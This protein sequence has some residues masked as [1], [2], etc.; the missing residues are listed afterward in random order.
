MSQAGLG[1]DA[2]DAA[3]LDADVLVIGS[4][5]GGA[6]SA[7]RLAEA[8]QRVIVTEQGQRIGPE[9]MRAAK[10]RPYTRLNWAP[11]LGQR[12]YFSQR[13]FR[14]VGILGGV[15][16]GGGS[17]VWGAVML[18]PKPRFY[19]ADVWQRL[20]LDFEAELAPHLDTARRM[21]GVAT[22]PRMSAQDDFLRATA[23]R[24][25]AGETFGPVPQAIHFG[26]P[27]RT[28]ADPYFDGAGPARTGCVF[29]AGCLSGCPHGAKS[30]LD[31]N[32]LHLA[33]RHGAD[34]R[35]GLRAERITPLDSMS[36]EGG[37]GY[38]VDF[39]AMD[40]GPAQRI[41][42]RRLVLAAGVL[43]TV[44]LLLTARD[45]H[46]TLPDVSPR[47]GETVRTNSEALTFILNRDA[48]IDLTDGASISS[49]FH[50]DAHTHITQNRMD[51]AYRIMRWM[52]VPMIDDA[53]PLRRAIKTL[54]ALVLR[55][56]IVW[57]NA[58]ARRYTQRLTT[59]TV[60]QD[61]DSGVGLTLR[62]PWWAPWRRRLASTP[63]AHGK[64]A[65][66]YL[67]VANRATRIFA[68]VSGGIPMS[69]SAEAI[70]G[71]AMTAHILGGCPMGS[72]PDD[73][74]I[75]ADHQI[76]GYPGLYVVDGSAIPANLGVNPSL[77]ITAMAERFAQ[78]LVGAYDNGHECSQQSDAVGRG[79]LAHVGESGRVERVAEH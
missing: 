30:S 68:D 47:L 36:S 6:V 15:G 52:A 78:R 16:L 74:V 67:A 57:R 11:A 53:H 22:N 50:A 51:G 7:L 10:A 46:R 64:R 75:D 43:G 32:Y 1:T 18:P 8:G 39:A 42:A 63:P 45:V 69:S 77:T 49:D 21:L 62:R 38:A 59:L 41:T 17:L 60:M 66:S 40:G 23:Q 26:E 12:G 24:M 25:G 27:G 72:S 19:A 9:E 71:R 76:F 5:F 29:C 33:A 73:G 20:G 13:I 28:V 14:H 2:L 3:T 61:D 58:F 34:I 44:E 79:G 70:G 56:D 37:G 54:L 4:G 55:P 35:T 48:K 65:P 31:Q